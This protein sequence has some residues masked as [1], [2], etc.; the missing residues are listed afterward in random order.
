MISKLK[1]KAK[2]ILLWSQKYTQTDMLYLGKG[3]FWLSS[4]F[5]LTSVLGLAQIIIFANFLPKEV[6]GTYKYILALAGTFSF[7]TLTGMNTAVTQAAAQSESSAILSYA[8]KVQLK[9]NFIFTAVITGLSAYYFINNNILFAESLFVLGLIFPL[10][11]T[12]NTYGAFLIGKKDFR[13]AS[14]YGTVTPVIQTISLAIGALLTQDVF[15]LILIY[16]T[17]GLVPNLFFYIRTFKIY[18]SDTLKSEDKKSVLEYS[19]H[20]SFMHVLSGIAQ[21]VDKIVIFHYLGAV[22]LAVYGL[23]LAVPERIRGYTKNMG[24]MIMPKLSEKTL[25]D[26]NKTFYKRVL[27][28]MAMGAIVSIAYILIAPSFYRILFPKYLEA[29]IYSQ[30]FSLTLIFILPANYMSGVFNAHKMLRALYF[31]SLSANVIKIS[32]YL[33]L[34]KYFG[35]WGVIYS[36]LIVYLTGT[37]YNFHLWSRELKKE[38]SASA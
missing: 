15:I 36:M 20:L 27:Q 34:G 2:E 7:L 11:T 32:L 18:K 21:Y 16:S 31:S 26:I 25:E 5:F 10:A 28:G 8:V 12:F 9:W 23:A 14:L 13:R 33:I 4:T 6:Y 22:Q 3:G 38:Q 29:V 24:A 30:I 1:N 17:T 37:L 19:K 35:I